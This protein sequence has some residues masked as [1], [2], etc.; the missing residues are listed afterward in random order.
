MIAYNRVGLTG[1]PRSSR[2]SNALVTNRRAEYF[3]H[4]NVEELYLNDASWYAEQEPDRFAFHIGEQVR[5]PPSRPPILTAA[6]LEHR[7][8]Q[9][10]RPHVQGQHLFVRHP[11]S[12]N[13][14]CGR[15]SRL[16]PRRARR[17]D[18]RY[19]LVLL[20]W[21]HTNPLQACSSTATLPISKRSCPT[22]SATR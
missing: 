10:D 6:G 15:S 3:Q 5:H 7:H 8:R 2:F 19:V 11:R 14:L 9:Q 12:G 21:I 17:Q 13:G 18:S 4:R 1:K 16:R 20:C 22:Q